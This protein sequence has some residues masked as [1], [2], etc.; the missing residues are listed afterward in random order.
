MKITSDGKKYISKNVESPIKTLA[1]EL[2][3]RGQFNDTISDII[4]HV[5]KNIN[6]ISK[7]EDA[8]EQT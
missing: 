6:Q 7:W 1:G 2:Q 5:L 8:D 3:K 4:T